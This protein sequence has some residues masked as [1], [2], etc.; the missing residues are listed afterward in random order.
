[1]NPPESGRW[2]RAFGEYD[3]AAVCEGSQHSGTAESEVESDGQHGEVD[4]VAGYPA[5]DRRRVGIV[6]VVVMGSGDQLG[7]AGCPS[8]QEEE[9]DVGWLWG[10]RRVRGGVRALLESGESQLAWPRFSRHYDVAK[11]IR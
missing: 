6:G 5:G 8:R 11:R 1:M 3:L 9:C 10:F 2:I 4:V 7:Q